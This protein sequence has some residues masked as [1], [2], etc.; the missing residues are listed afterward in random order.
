MCDY[1]CRLTE[2]RYMNVDLPSP[3]SFVHENE[4]IFRI[5]KKEIKKSKNISERLFHVNDQS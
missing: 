2:F 3:G 5:K 4:I 1:Y